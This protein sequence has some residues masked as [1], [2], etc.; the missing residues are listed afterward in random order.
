[1]L[2]S[3]SAAANFG[4]PA[5]GRAGA[6]ANRRPPSKNPLSHTQPCNAR[7]HR[8]GNGNTEG[9]SASRAPAGG[10]RLRPPGARCCGAGGAPGGGAVARK[11]AGLT[12]GG[13]L[14]DSKRAKSE[15]KSRVSG[16]SRDRTTALGQL[17][18]TSLGPAR[19]GGILPSARSAPGPMRSSAPAA[20]LPGFPAPR[21]AVASEAIGG[22]L[23]GGLGSPPGR[24]GRGDSRADRAGRGAAHP[25]HDS[26]LASDFSPAIEEAVG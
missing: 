4:A 17:L 25:L 24:A 1:M 18:Q 9:C 8:T 16:V 12:R 15:G 26:T 3:R 13:S 20:P 23:R 2:P 22:P 6:M 5:S 10:A 11:D 19:R 14:V 7:R 21:L